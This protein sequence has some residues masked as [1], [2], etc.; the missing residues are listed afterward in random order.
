M[1]VCTQVLASLI[2]PMTPEMYKLTSPIL[3]GLISNDVGRSQKLT[4]QLEKLARV[5]PE[6]RIGTL[7][8]TLYNAF[9]TDVFGSG[10]EYPAVVLKKK[11]ECL[12]YNQRS[13]SYRRLEKFM[14]AGLRSRLIEK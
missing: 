5:H 1:I 6:V 14:S 13:T 9:C 3:V 10:K 12:E 2:L 11:N 4:E 7:N 8:C